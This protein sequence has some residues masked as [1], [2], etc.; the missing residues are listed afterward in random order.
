MHS[1][2]SRLPE[3]PEKRR[4]SVEPPPPSIPEEKLSTEDKPP[5]TVPPIFHD[6]QE[7]PYGNISQMLPAQNHSL[8]TS[9]LSST[10]DTATQDTFYEPNLQHRGSGDSISLDPDGYI[11]FTGENAAVQD[12]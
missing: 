10:D 11:E 3:I 4:P 8:A 1:I 12:V 5:Q 2:E 6:N 9:A 7:R